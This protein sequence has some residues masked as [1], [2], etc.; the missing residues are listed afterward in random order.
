MNSYFFPIPVWIVVLTSEKKLFFIAWH[1][2]LH[3]FG[4][5][6]FLRSMMAILTFSWSHLKATQCNWREL[7]N[8]VWFWLTSKVSGTLSMNL[9][10]LKFTETILTLFI[11]L[12]Q[13]LKQEFTKLLAV[14]LFFLHL[15]QLKKI[16]KHF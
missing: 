15:K 9:Y 10:N 2:P 13:S 7:R 14:F 8:S 4:S 3:N 11:W 5:S 1:V 6:R 12:H 16:Q